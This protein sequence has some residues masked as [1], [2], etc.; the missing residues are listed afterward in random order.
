MQ[1]LFNLDAAVPR[2]YPVRRMK[3][4]ALGLALL[5]LAGPLHAQA[6]RFL[7]DLRFFRS[8]HP[9]VEGS[10]GEERAMEYIRRRLD[11]LSVAHRRIDASESDSIHTFSSIIEATVPGRLPDTLILAVPVDHAPGEAPERDGAVNPALA[12]SLLETLSRSRSPSPL[13]VRVLFLGA[14]HSGPAPQTAL[15][16]PQTELRPAQSSSPSDPL[17]SRLYLKDFF[18]EHRV[19]VLYLNLKALPSRLILRSAAPRVAAPYWLI[20]AAT[21][22]L[23]EAGLFFLVR[24]NENQIFRIGLS[25]EHTVIEPWLRAGYPA[26]SLEGEYGSE[27]GAAGWAGSFQ[28]FFT[29]F[30]ARFARGIPETWDLHYLFFQAR[31]FYLIVDEKT[32]LILLL[33]AL[34]AILLYGVAFTGRVRKY[35][36]TVGRRVWT[37]PVIFLLGFGSLYV[38]TRL[39]GGVLALRRMS[40]LWAELPLLFLAFKLLFALLPLLL[41]RPLLRRLPFSRNGS[42]YSAAALLFL[43]LDIV[44]L[45]LYNISFTYYFLWAFFFALL[46]AVTPNKLLKL[47]FLLA[48]PYWLLKTLVELF[49]LPQPEFCRLVLL[50]PVGGNLLLTAVLLPFVLMLLRIE[51]VLPTFTRVHR[52]IRFRVAGEVL[53]LLLAG[54]FVSFLLY[55]PYNELNR[56]PVTAEGEID[57]AAGTGSL[58]LSSLAPLDGLRLLAGGRPLLLPAG[59]D[60]ARAALTDLPPPPPVSLASHAFLDRKNVTVLFEPQRR[61]DGIRLRLLGAG[62]FVLYDANFPYIR[63]P[64]G[65][66]YEILIGR[67]PPI[68]LSVKLTLPRDGD[69]SLDIVLEYPGLPPDVEVVGG[70]MRLEARHTVRERLVLKT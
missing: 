60:A 39:L 21:Q 29:L 50:S 59:S 55:Q 24:G 23:E 13:S 64:H 8:L 12:L 2:S 52:R 20:D 49:A 10:E 68:P 5:C 45:A 66:E 61:P 11:A 28:R 18:P 67:N 30:G 27:A 51:M 26:L 58:R 22:A 7:D 47:I 35:A 63:G 70:N 54:L 56:Q 34:T 69:Y 25:S 38:A 16:V 53:A 48:A 40:R 36:R 15:A 3:R 42:F 32:Y 46:F 4:F 6:A 44:V 17:G 57:L 19:T 43:F 65:D 37:L 1:T 9:R 33:A 41:L 14:E 31:S 62:S